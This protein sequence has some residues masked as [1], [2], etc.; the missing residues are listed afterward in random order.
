MKRREIIKG[1]KRA[2]FTIKEGSNHS[3]VYKDG[4]YV[5]AI[6]RQ[7]EVKESVV[8]AIEKQTKTKLR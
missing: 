4:K 6:S 2:G 8:K 5:S 3:K 7:S 1:L